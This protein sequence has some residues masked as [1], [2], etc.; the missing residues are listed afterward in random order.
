MDKILPEFAHRFDEIGELDDDR[1]QEWSDD[2]TRELM[3]TIR[4]AAVPP[5]ESI[6]KQSQ[7]ITMENVMPNKNTPHLERRVITASTIHFERR[8]DKSITVEGIAAPYNSD[9]VDLG[10]FVERY[11]PGCFTRTL[12]SGPTF[13]RWS[14]TIPAW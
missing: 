11:A 4:A 14:I 12:R 1:Q 3:K 13:G 10:Y 2:L 5:K 8:E 7:V 6:S 9:S